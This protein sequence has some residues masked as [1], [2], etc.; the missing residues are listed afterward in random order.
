MEMAGDLFSIVASLYREMMGSV[1]R[2]ISSDFG[3]L[4]GLPSRFHSWSSCISVR[5]LACILYSD[6]I[7]FYQC[8]LPG[9]V[10][11]FLLWAVVLLD[12]V[13]QVLLGLLAHIEVVVW[14]EHAQ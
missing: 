7:F 5:F 9:R 13:S 4:F 11:Q 3:H 12:H 14:T 8:F 6:I 10:G 2:V 1:L